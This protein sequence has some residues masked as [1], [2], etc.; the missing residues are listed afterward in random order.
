MKEDIIHQFQKAIPGADRALDHDTR[1]ARPNQPL[2]TRPAQGQGLGQDPEW[3]RNRSRA[4]PRR[5]EAQSTHEEGP[6]QDQSQ[7]QS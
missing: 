5:R 7:D 3:I 6:G 2:S 1:K 4:A